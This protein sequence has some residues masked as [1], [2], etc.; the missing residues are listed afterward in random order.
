M[1][2]R[3]GNQEYGMRWKENVWVGKWKEIYGDGNRQ[4]E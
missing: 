4:K 1:H 3:K 2:E